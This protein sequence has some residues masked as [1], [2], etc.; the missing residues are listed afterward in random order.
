MKMRWAH[1][2]FALLEKLQAG[3]SGK[4][5]FLQDHLGVHFRMDITYTRLSQEA[6]MGLEL[7]PLLFT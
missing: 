3:R 4:N 1:V 7:K 5:Y 2:M 6:D